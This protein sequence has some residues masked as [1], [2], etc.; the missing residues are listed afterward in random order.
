M[1]TAWVRT[2][3]A[4]APAL[5]RRG[6]P[7]MGLPTPVS[8]LPV[9]VTLQGAP[10]LS[11]P[12]GAALRAQWAFGFPRVPKPLAQLT[13][14]F[15]HYPAG[16]QPVAAMHLLEVLP[17]GTLLDPFVGGGTSMIEALRSGRT[18]IGADASPLAL[19]ASSHHTWLACDE[20]LLDLRMQATQVLRRVDAGYVGVGEPRD[21]GEDEA[22]AAEGPSITTQ[23]RRRPPR[24]ERNGRGRTTFKSWTPL[25]GELERLLAEPS[26]TSD[27]TGEA[28]AHEVLSPLWFCFAAAQQRSERFRFSNPLA[29][30]DA[31]VDEYCDALRALRTHVPA[32]TSGLLSGTVTSS[33]V[34]SSTGRGSASGG[35]KLL[36]CDARVLSLAEQGL[37]PADAV[38]TSP[39]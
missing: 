28:D 16:M 26:V 13:H 19:F 17:R 23:E 1:L 2:I 10:S 32:P 36:L 22:E 37:P 8:T 11:E 34:T 35:A 5:G 21:G 7:L 15:L 14:G 20:E 12:L 18:C 39:P 27:A 38:L 24:L 31:T 9:A 33:T 3:L 25:K 6:R 30:F 29:S 4:A